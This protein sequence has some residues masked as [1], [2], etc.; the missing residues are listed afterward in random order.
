MGAGVQIAAILIIVGGFA[1]IVVY[2]RWKSTS[3]TQMDID[4]RFEDEDEPS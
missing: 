3:Q 1:M 4:D 2:Q